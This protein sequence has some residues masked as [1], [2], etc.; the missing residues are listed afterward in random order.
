MREIRKTRL[1][2]KNKK[3][4]NIRMN[5]KNF[6][7]FNY[8]Y[9]LLKLNPIN[10]Q[11]TLSPR[12]VQSYLNKMDYVLYEIKDHKGILKN[13]DYD[14]WKQE[15]IEDLASSGY[16]KL[17]NNNYVITEAGKE[18]IKHDS[19]LYYNRKLERPEG[20]VK[21]PVEVERVSILKNTYIIAIVGFLILAT[22][23]IFRLRS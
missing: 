13:D 21:D 9:E 4:P 11:G 15:V 17:R 2:K 16:I 19:F 14:T 10:M 12:S 22:I 1:N 5:S 3:V 8:S 7:K 18:V 23:T 20:E 6:V